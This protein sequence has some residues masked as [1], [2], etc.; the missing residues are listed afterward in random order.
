MLRSNIDIRTLQRLLG[1]KHL[2]TTE[3]YLAAFNDDQL[4]N[5]IESS[6]LAQMVAG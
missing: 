6:T 3:R 4:L 1:H 2:Q 5:Q